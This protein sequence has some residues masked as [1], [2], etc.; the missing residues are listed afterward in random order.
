MRE[1]ALTCQN[2]VGRWL[3]GKETFESAVDHCHSIVSTELCTA[4]DISNSDHLLSDTGDIDWRTEVFQ[5]SSR[6][7]SSN[8]A[9]PGA[10]PPTSKKSKV[11]SSPLLMRGWRTL[12][13]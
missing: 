13:T 12:I 4:D 11:G 3:R 1:G 6:M 8:I 5:Y 9:H 2:D 7:A 10:Q